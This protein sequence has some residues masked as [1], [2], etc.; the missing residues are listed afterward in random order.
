MSAWTPST[1]VQWRSDEGVAEP[2]LLALLACIATHGALAPAARATGLSYRHAWSL[3]QPWARPGPC[4]LV[5]LRRG[6]GATLTASGQALL[7]RHAALTRHLATAASSWLEAHGEATALA[8]CVCA[9]SHDLLIEQLPAFAR[10][11]GLEL[12]IAFRGSDEAIAALVAGR[13]AIAG[14]HVP[15]DGSIARREAMAPLAARGDV[16]VLRMFRRMQGLIVSRHGRR[17]IARLDDLTHRGVRFVNRQRGSGTRRLLDALLAAHD[18]APSRIDGYA[19]EEFTHAAVAATVAAGDA[20]AG[21]GIAAAADRFAL[22]FVP[23][24]QEWYCLALRRDQ[25]DP[26]GE[27]ALVATLR[28]ANWRKLVEETP[29]YALPS[30]IAFARPRGAASGDAATKRPGARA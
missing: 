3:L 15:V 21:F 23:I 30:R 28:S 17:R 7:A 24:A 12:D 27:H 22:G 4:A 14:F 16:A 18:I 19:R 8:P 9:A 2:R 6:E 26:R 20:D 10:G 13:V 25:V 1:V 5:S 11:H 29:G